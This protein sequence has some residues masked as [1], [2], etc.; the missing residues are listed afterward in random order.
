MSQRQLNSKGRWVFALSTL[1]LGVALVV[2]AQIQGEA[3][4]SS[5]GSISR[6]KVQIPSGATSTPTPIFTTTCVAQPTWQPGPT[7][8]PGLYALQGGM[9]NNGYFYVTGGQ[10]ANN[11]P[12]AMVARFNPINSTWDTSLPLPVAVGQA[13]MG[14]SGAKIFVA[15]GYLGGTGGTSVTTTLQIFDIAS[16]TWSFGAS[17]PAR[18]EAAAGTVLN[19]KFYVM[20]GDDFTNAVTTNY[21]YDIAND[22]WSTGAPLPAPRTNVYS[23]VSS[24]GNGLVYLFGGVDGSLSAVDTLYSYNPV[25]NSWTTL[26]PSNSAP[27]CCNYT[28]ISPYG[29]GKLIA[30]GGGATNFAPSNIVKIYDIAT[31]TWSTGP[32]LL[33]ARLGHAQG[34]LPDGR[35][36]VYSGLQSST[37]ATN[38]TELLGRLCSAITVTPTPTPV[39]PPSF[40]AVRIENFAFTPMTSTVSLGT[41][42][43]W[44][45]F[46]A[47]AHTS[48]SDTALWDSGNLNQG[49]FFEFTF[50][51][52]GT[53]PY[54]CALHPTMLGSIV[55]L[56][57]CPPTSTPTITPT[58]TRTFTP[59]NTVTTCPTPVRT[60]TYT[61]TPV[62]T[63]TPASTNTPSRTSTP[64]LTNTPTDTSVATVTQT[65]TPC[66]IP[67][68]DVT[69]TDY[70]YQGVRWL[71]CRGAISGYGTVFLPYNLTTRGQ[72]TKIVVLAYGMPIYTPSTPTFRDVPTSHTF[73]QYIETAY[74]QN[75]IS[76]YTC[77][78]GC[79]EF[80]PDANVTRAQL[81]K[82]VVTAASWALINPLT[83]TFR[84]VPT[85]D[86]FYQY[87]E[88]AVC[89]LVVTGYTCGTGCL[90]FRPGANATRGQISKMVY[91]AVLHLSC[92]PPP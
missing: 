52:P 45:N 23:T 46:D 38:S 4:A 41:T 92:L 66:G 68:T 89:H 71:Y 5:S 83:P 12:V 18:V 34:T 79:L 48:T 53:Y 29:A 76:G 26:A 74:Q 86:T 87:I 85:G 44:T 32:S 3:N 60:P 17:L 25:S 9:A 1:I 49:Q 33:L 37:V 67:F 70:F 75:I 11:T 63:N 10:L 27:A 61:S 28:G 8:G 88:T 6:S 36:I 13:S 65:T 90:E 20:G 56:A 54:H 31:N 73:Y 72:L 35:V 64:A 84:D 82:I 91:N 80:R 58:P 55:V 15:G 51:S 19:G 78:T 42:I 2:I 7:M 81:T 14:T 22:I 62:I 69:P 40:A 47:S 30:A 57:G 24:P 77:G 21:V 16:S 50:N 59:T 39:C 43:R